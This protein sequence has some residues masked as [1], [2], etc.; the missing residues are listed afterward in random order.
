MTTASSSK[1]NPHDI[2]HRLSSSKRTT[3]TTTHHLDHSSRAMRAKHHAEF[4]R[5]STAKPDS[6]SDDVHTA[7]LIN[8][9]IPIHRKHRT[10]HVEAGGDEIIEDADEESTDIRAIMSQN[11]PPSERYPSNNSAIRLQQQG[12]GD[13]YHL[14]S[15]Q[16]HRIRNKISSKSPLDVDDSD[17][18]HWR[19]F[20]YLLTIVLLAFVIYRFLLTIWPKPKKNVLEQII[21]DLSKFFTL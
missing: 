20:L 14:H 18:S 3:T 19:V 15:K 6:G 11:K 1:T 10:R 2:Q 8:E 4:S 9:S 7:P 17:L 21:D 13:H 5:P 12:M 16:Q